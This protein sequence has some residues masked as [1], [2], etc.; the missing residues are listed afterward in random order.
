MKLALCLLIVV[1]SAYIGRLFSKRLEQR[2]D[3]FREYQS[4]MTQVS[5]KVVGVGLELYRVLSECRGDIAGPLLRACAIR[6][7]AKP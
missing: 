5:D 7:K 4:A 6:L 3:F 2:L 1:I